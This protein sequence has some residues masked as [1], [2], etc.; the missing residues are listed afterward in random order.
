MNFFGGVEG[1]DA[2]LSVPFA[3]DGEGGN[4]V[5]EGEEVGVFEGCDSW[6]VG[7]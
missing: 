6:V 1:A 3:G 5:G 2:G 7:V 4:E